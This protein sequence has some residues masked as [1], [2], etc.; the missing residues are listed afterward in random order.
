V[1]TALIRNLGYEL[2][3]MP[4]YTLVYRRTLPEL[5]AIVGTSP[6]LGVSAG[7]RGRTSIRILEPGLVVRRLTHG[8]AFGRILGPR[9]LAIDRSVRELEISEHL[10]AQ[11]IPTPELVGLRIARNRVFYSVEVISRMIPDSIDLLAF[12][13]RHPDDG[14]AVIRHTG[15]LIQAIHNA[16]VYHADLHV[17]NI[18]LDRDLTPW[19][20]D[21]DKARRFTEMPFLLR[22]KNT[23][24]FLNSL[25]KWHEK[26]RISLPG[27]WRQSFMRGYSE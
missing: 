4:P 23:R 20:I 7:I 11:G 24:R 10:I 5:P 22:Y 14:A 12:L 13:E 19:V 21:L 27:D 1:D 26:G 18:V 15:A 6:V 3:E 17:K 8:G 2:R 16:G 9:F 25:K